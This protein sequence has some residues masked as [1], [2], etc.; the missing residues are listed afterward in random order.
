MHCGQQFLLFLTC[1]CRARFLPELPP[2]GLRGL[3]LEPDRGDR[4]DA[5][6]EPSDLSSDMRRVLGQC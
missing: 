1:P 2:R 5:E 3:P 4:G 6:G